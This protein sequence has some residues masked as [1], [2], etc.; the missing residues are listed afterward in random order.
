MS[1]DRIDLDGIVEALRTTV[2][3]PPTV[4]AVFRG[5]EIEFSSVQDVGSVPFVLA[6]ALLNLEDP[7]IDSIF[8]AFKSKIL[9]AGGRT[10]WPDD[11]HD[12]DRREERAVSRD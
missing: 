7:R 2:L 1:K 4:K 5:R 6:V 3:T 11:Q 10:V 12:A 8:R 9:Y